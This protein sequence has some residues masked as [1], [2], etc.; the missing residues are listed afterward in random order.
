MPCGPSGCTHDNP[1]LA[2]L[3][4]F[5][6]VL[7]DLAAGRYPLGVAMPM[8]GPID[9]LGALVGVER[10]CLGFAESPQL[11]RE[12]LGILTDV[13][14]EVVGGAARAAAALRRGHGQLRAVRALG[15]GDECR[16]PV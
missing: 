10:M 7:R 5:Y 2:K 4:E 3:R 11:V 12:A 13:W 6:V 16:H 9:M 1:W 8:R 15:A 14:I